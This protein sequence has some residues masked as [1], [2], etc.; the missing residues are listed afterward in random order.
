[1]RGKWGAWT[2]FTAC[3]EPCGGGVKERRRH[4]DKPADRSGR[5][6]RC[7]GP[8]T[9]SKPCNTHACEGEGMYLHL[10]FTMFVYI[11]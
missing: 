6:H 3:S 4:C 9:E 8:D 7:E 5:F 11:Y 10:C 2:E 1:M